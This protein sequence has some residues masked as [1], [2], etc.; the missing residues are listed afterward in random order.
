MLLV[1]ARTGDARLAGL[2]VAAFTVPTL[3]A[4]PVPGAYLDRLPRKRPL[5]TASQLVL[6]LDLAALLAATGRVS[7]WA[8]AALAF[9][10]GASSASRRTA[11]RRCSPPPP[12]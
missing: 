9:T 6:A 4:G 2:L 3:I 1:I 7:G 11:T 10:A 5:F 8:P 12:A